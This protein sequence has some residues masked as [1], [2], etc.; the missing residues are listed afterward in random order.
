[1]K[2]EYSQLK[3]RWGGYDGYDAWFNRTLSNADLV[4]IATYDACVSGLQR[5]RQSVNNDWPSF[6]A[7]VRHLAK[8]SAA[9]RS[10]LCGLEKAD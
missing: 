8:G 6:Y 5:L 9:E 2:F 1:L 3:A 7:A 10:K 4:P